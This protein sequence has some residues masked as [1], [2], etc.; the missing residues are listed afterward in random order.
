MSQT[1]AIAEHHA[2]RS[3]ATSI[4]RIGLRLGPLAGVATDA[5][6]FAFDTL[7]QGTMAAGAE[8]T[9][10]ELPATFVCLDCAASSESISMTFICP[11][12][13]GPTRLEDGGRELELAFLEVTDHV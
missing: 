1:L 11:V 5:L 7:R 4:L 9:I 12:C 2:K 6:R 3:H 13:G 10:E 8:L